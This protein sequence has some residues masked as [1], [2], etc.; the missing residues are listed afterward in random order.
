MGPR[1]LMA[2]SPA[3]R[4]SRLRSAVA[5]AFLHARKHTGVGIV[6]AVAYFDPGNWAVDLQAGSDWGFRLLFPVLLA[7]IFAAFLQVLATRL[8]VVTGLDLA[9]H[10]R[11]LL[12]DR[13][14][15]KLFYRR[16]VL[17]PL[18]AVS[19]V[20][21]VATD[22]A[23]LL[24]SAIA[25]VL[26][27]PSL[28]IWHGVL[29][30]SVDVLLLIALRDPLRSTPVKAF[31]LLIAALVISV[32]VCMVI[33][34]SRVQVQWDDAFEGFLPSKVLFG[35]SG[36]YTSVGI[37][38]AT[39]MPHSIFLGSTLAT[40]RRVPVDPSPADASKP[41]SL[42]SHQPEDITPRD[43]PSTMLRRV[44]S[45]VTSSFRTPPPSPHT[46]RVKRH[47]D[48]ENNSLAFIQ[49]HLNH[50]IFD[51]VGSLLGF[52]VLINS[53]ILII[54][55]MVFYYSNDKMAMDRSASLFDA[56]K[57]IHRI[58]GKA[59]ATLFAVALLAAGQSSSI[60]ATIAGQAVAEGFLNW[61]I[62]PIMRRLFTRLIA[63]IPAMSVAIALGRRGIDGLLVASQVILAIVLPFI[64]LPLVLLTSSK[65]VMRVRKPDTLIANAGEG[66]PTCED[67][68]DYSSGKISTL[69]GVAI[70]LVILTANVYV[71]ATLIQNA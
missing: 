50:A 7:G 37:L 14:T 15:H 62:S 71:I 48:R 31:E 68:V 11:V 28:E 57:A 8:G 17:Y 16:F 13:P 21:I 26:L 51:V 47:A 63:V 45:F 38:G 27:F 52:A 24:G 40:Q 34:V 60:I 33:V 3:P 29:I 39:I 59:A 43:P 67:V 10:C 42:Q 4:S 61:R 46:T 9:S 12:Y 58:V 69:V 23:E 44:V 18:Y 30:T 36:L 66:E 64:I 20:A 65:T 22:L 49:V 2:T 54:A 55:S 41:E 6:C 35:P 25:L 53:M 56:Y 19:E 70:W 5:T 1:H 32:L